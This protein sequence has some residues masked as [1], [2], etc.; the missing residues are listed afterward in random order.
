MISS[1]M[2]AVRDAERSITAGAD[3]HIFVFTYHKKNQFL[4]KLPMLNTNI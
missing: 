4:M 1:E 2:L 3:I